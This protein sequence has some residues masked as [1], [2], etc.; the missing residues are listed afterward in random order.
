MKKFWWHFRQNNPRGIFKGPALNCYM[1]ANSANEASEI[2]YRNGA[3][4]DTCPCCGDRWYNAE[5][6][7]DLKL[8]ESL[9]EGSGPLVHE[10]DA[11]FAKDDGIPV[12]AILK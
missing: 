2:L 8:I 7:E 4:D 6:V 5:E 10:I 3:E 12:N 1:L 9:D 11:W